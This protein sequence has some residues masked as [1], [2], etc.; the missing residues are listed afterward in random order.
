MI[1]R[2]KENIYEQVEKT[3]ELSVKMIDDKN[4]IHV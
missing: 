1:S 3:T 2:V 4:S